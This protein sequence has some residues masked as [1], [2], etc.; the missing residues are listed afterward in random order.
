MAA[1]QQTGDQ[2]I[3]F[4]EVGGG[5]RVAIAVC[6]AGP[7]LVL[8]SWWVSNVE[9]NWGQPRFRAFVAGLAQRHRVIRYDRLGSGLSDRRADDEAAT[10]DA[11][12]RTL[13]AVVEQ[14]VPG[15]APV[16]LLGISYGGCL[17]IA[18]ADHHPRRVRRLVTFG[19]YAHGE[20]VAPPEVRAALLAMV[21]AHWGLGARV[22]TQ[23]WLPDA[24]EDERRELT[25]YQRSA[26][27]PATAADLLALAY[28]ADVRAACAR[29]RLP[30]LVLHRRDDRAAPLACGRELAA[31]IP[32]ARLL[33]LDGG[34]HP[35]WHG[36][37]AAV[38][39]ATLAFLTAAAEQ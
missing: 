32:G 37:A 20:E 33:P 15:G 34:A 22:L 5:R 16:D 25:A 36:R 8:P 18:Y 6:G 23:V 2:E 4:C 31:L 1:P 7:P 10:F 3:G 21:R 17:A 29:L 9:A 24:G 28:D 13:E 35:P 27:D 26:A 38:V 14:A 30:T 39:E 19:A 12:L 11:E